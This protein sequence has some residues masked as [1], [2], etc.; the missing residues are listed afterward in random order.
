MQKK[1]LKDAVSDIIGKP[2]GDI[3]DLLF[4]KKN[5]NEFLL[6][7]KLKLTINQT[8]NILYKLSDVGLVGFTRKKDKRKGWYTYF[9]TLNVNRALELLKQIIEKEIK[10]IKE[11]I[12]SRKT[13]SFY[14]C[15][16]CKIELTEETALTHDFVC[17][18]CGQVY[19]L[20]DSSNF[21]KELS[22][23]LTRLQR[24]LAS[25]DEEIG[26]NKEKEG[27]KRKERES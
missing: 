25:V 12:R 20:T 16:T 18:E 9:W 8:R 15:K 21:I 1:F 26:K 2:A 4:D 19:E 11:Q 7:K 27:K 14:S 23:R 17:P 5:V 13:K 24:D 3:V 6:A 10:Q 22:S